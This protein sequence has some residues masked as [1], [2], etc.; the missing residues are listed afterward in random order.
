MMNLAKWMHQ[1]LDRPPFH[2]FSKEANTEALILVSPE[3]LRVKRNV[4]E[5]LR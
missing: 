5:K 3:Y 4:N 2:G 1:E